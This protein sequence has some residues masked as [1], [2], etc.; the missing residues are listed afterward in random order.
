MDR[1][2][3]IRMVGRL[4]AILGLLLVFAP[5][6]LAETVVV[7]G[8]K[9]LWHGPNVE[10]AD[11]GIVAPEKTMLG[12]QAYDHHFL[13]TGMAPEWPFLEP[14]GK[15]PIDVAL[16]KKDVIVFP[17][18]GKTISLDTSSFPDMATPAAPYLLH[19]PEFGSVLVVQPFYMFRSKETRYRVSLYTSKGEFLR[20][21]DSLPTHRLTGGPGVLVAPER[22][23]CCENM[24]W[25]I[26]FFNP[27]SGG[28]SLFTCPPG[29]CGDLVLNRSQS[30]GALGLV[31][32]SFETLPGAGSIVETRLIV[33][34]PAGETLA[35]GRLAYAVKD[36]STGV[37][38]EWAACAS[39]VLLADA[40]PYAAKNLDRITR[41][42]D[43][44]WAFRFET[45]AGPKA[46]AVSGVSDRQTPGFEF[47]SSKKRPEE[48]ASHGNS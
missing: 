2:H 13:N 3:D 30:D 32:E 11:A 31:Y 12:D 40:S 35:D 39:R 42:T 25:N 43:G 46:W 23:G 17:V 24:T 22:A 18:S 36:P 28:V 38:P 19:D 48:R 20:E 14:L 15:P 16:I 26:R 34:S 8:A 41:L 10:K 21:Y 37:A 44:R 33:I 1:V 9:L 29:K 5:S 27:E 7:R 45:P 47:R 4:S 6:V